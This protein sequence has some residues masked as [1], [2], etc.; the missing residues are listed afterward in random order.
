MRQVM[1]IS[2]DVLL[3]CRQIVAVTVG[4]TVYLGGGYLRD[5][6]YGNNT[7]KD[8]DLFFVPKDKEYLKYIPVLNENLGL[9]YPVYDYC[10]PTEDMKNRGIDRV[11]GFVNNELSTQEFNYIIY[12]HFLSME[13]VALDFD[14]GIN[15]IVYDIEKDTVFR[16][17]NYTKHHY[18]KTIECLHE[19]SKERMWQRY[20]R[21]KDKFPDY[22]VVGEP[23]T[24]TIEKDCWYTSLKTKRSAAR[25]S[26]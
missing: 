8:V 6:E 22:A 2:P 15:Q 14:M 26:A 1:N 23:Q 7:P 13:E 9:G 10:N 3:I 4:Y 25:A 17:D 20:Q 18:D 16:S 5:L 12:D 24:T 21:M 11:V 19:F